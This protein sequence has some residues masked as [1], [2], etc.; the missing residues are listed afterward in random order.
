MIFNEDERRAC[1]ACGDSCM[2][3]VHPACCGPAVWRSVFNTPLILKT[4][5]PGGRAASGRRGVSP[6][7]ARYGMFVAHINEH[8]ENGTVT[9]PT[10]LFAPHNK[11]KNAA[12]G[13]DLV[14][15]NNTHST[16]FETFSALAHR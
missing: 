6:A 5:R 12:H 4:D 3:I 7:T 10:T 8:F 1:C 13:S 15:R 2:H 14:I 9:P 11:C 16:V